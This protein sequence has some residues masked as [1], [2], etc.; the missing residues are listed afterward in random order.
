[1][2]S[3]AP[4]VVGKLRVRVPVGARAGVD[5]V[6]RHVA[7][8]RRA[9]RAGVRA[10]G[11]GTGDGNGEREHTRR[12]DLRDVVL[13]DRPQER[14]DARVA[15]E[16]QERRRVLRRVFGLGA[17]VVMTR[18]FAGAVLGVICSDVQARQRD[19]HAG[20]RDAGVVDR[21]ARVGIGRR[22]PKDRSMNCCKTDRTDRCRRG[23]AEPLQPKSRTASECLCRRVLADAVAPR[24]RCCSVRVPSEHVTYVP[25]CCTTL[26][27]ATFS[28]G[29][30]HAHPRFGVAQGSPEPEPPPSALPPSGGCELS[31]PVSVP[32]PAHRARHAAII[33]LR[34]VMRPLS[35]DYPTQEEEQRTCRLS[36]CTDT[37]FF[38]G[39]RE[40]KKAFS[41]RTRAC[42]M[43]ADRNKVRPSQDLRTR[44]KTRV[45]RSLGALSF[46]HMWPGVGYRQQRRYRGG[47]FR[48]P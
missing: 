5:D 7:H 37:R 21:E 23:R 4:V 25:D 42:P 9:E 17:I 35:R 45:W 20:E 15:A 33:A 44:V 10:H 32:S 6:D 41:P 34:S 29:V 3:A 8:D 36:K 28:P 13:V 43:W 2:L 24:C 11:D 47:A 38:C 39:F 46:H 27:Q 40:R 16:R 14:R 1:M 48:W 30:S 18:S 19:G 26:P 31:H 22:A 12:A